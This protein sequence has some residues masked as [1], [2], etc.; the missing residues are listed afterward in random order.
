MELIITKSLFT[1]PEKDN[2][3]ISSIV[4]LGPQ[5]FIA[6]NWKDTVSP[7]CT[8]IQESSISSP[9]ISGGSVHVGEATTL[10]RNWTGIELSGIVLVALIKSSTYIKIKE[11]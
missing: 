3:A 7:T 8:N 11:N 9:M 5:L 10:T 2:V 6:I 4:T 1:I